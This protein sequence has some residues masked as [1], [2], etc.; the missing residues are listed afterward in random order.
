QWHVRVAAFNA[1]SGYTIEGSYSTDPVEEPEFTVLENGVAET[2]ISVAAGAEARFAIDVPEGATDL[3]V[4]MA[5]GT[6]DADLYVRQS[7]WP[8]N[9]EYDC[10]PYLSGN[11]ELCTFATPEDGRWYI[12]LAGF[13]SATGISLTASYTTGSGVEGP[14][15]LSARH[16]FALKGQRVRVPLTWSS[17]GEV[18]VRFNGT[19]VATT[20]LE[21][22]T[23][24]FTATAVGAG[25]ATYQVCNAGSTTECS[26]TITVEYTA[27]R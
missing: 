20:E 21:R 10:R 5:G 11:N 17:E 4:Q 23:H 13:S 8:T 26:E 22:Y 25:S 24:T 19:V 7:G 12:R 16:A 2:G 15:D 1:S 6:G 27:R 18:D 14:T 9:T 3:R